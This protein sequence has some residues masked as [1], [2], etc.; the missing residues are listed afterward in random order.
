MW[1]HKPPFRRAARWDGVFPIKASEALETWE[2]LT[3]PELRAIVAYTFSQRTSAAPFDVIVSGQ[4]TADGAV[5]PTGTVAAYAE[6]GATWWIEDI[7]P[8]RFGW[9]DQ[10]PWPVAAMRERVRQGPPQ[11]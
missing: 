7:V 10:G 8:W 11:E 4:S 1:P 6:A 3:P 9:E 2:P 5:W